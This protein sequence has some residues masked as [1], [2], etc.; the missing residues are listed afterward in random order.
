MWRLLYVFQFLR[1][2]KHAIESP[3]EYH[4]QKVHLQ[5]HLELFLKAIQNFIHQE[6][7]TQVI[8]QNTFIRWQIQV[9]GNF[10]FTNHILLLSVIGIYLLCR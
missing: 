7:H 4:Y 6:K 3:P 2:P 1:Q 5:T 10:Y 8:Y 9:I